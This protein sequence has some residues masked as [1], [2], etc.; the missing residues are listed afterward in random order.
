MTQMTFPVSVPATRRPSP[1][2][3]SRRRILGAEFATAF[4]ISLGPRPD[5]QTLSRYADRGA[6][7]TPADPGTAVAGPRTDPAAVRPSITSW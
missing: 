5:P 2:P 4:V 6:L 7:V 3:D 1:A